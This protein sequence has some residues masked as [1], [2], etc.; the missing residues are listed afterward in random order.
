MLD[1]AIKS[2]VTSLVYL[3]KIQ[4]V[5][6]GLHNSRLFLVDSTNIPTNCAFA[7]CSL[8]LTEICSCLVLHSTCSVIVEE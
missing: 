7:E 4:R 8:V 6:V 2:P 1:T 5:A 3:T